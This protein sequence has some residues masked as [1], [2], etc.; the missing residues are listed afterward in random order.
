LEGWVAGDPDWVVHGTRAA[1]VLEERMEASMEEVHYPS[2]GASL[3]APRFVVA[4]RPDSD[5]VRMAR[6]CDPDAKPD[7]GRCRGGD[8]PG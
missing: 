7:L 3:R 8:P 5:W 4:Y 6:H 1:C 2:V